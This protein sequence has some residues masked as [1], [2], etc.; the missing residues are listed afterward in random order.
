MNTIYYRTMSEEE[1]KE[2]KDLRK[3]SKDE[4]IDSLLFW[5]ERYLFL[6]QYILKH[7]D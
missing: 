4:L 2:I 7:L 1:L 6:N 3:Q 5:K